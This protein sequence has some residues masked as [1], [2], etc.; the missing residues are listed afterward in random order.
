MMEGPRA[1]DS[2]TLEYPKLRNLEF[3]PVREGETQ[4]VGLRDPQGISKE[5][6]F[7]PPNVFYLIQF[8]DGQHSRNQIAGEYLKRFG[9]LLLPNWVDKFLTEL[10]EKLFLEGER[11][12]TAKKALAEAY[13][14]ETIRPAAH[15][16]KSYDADPQKVEAQLDECFRSKE[17]PGNARSEH[18][19]QRIKAIVVPHVEFSMAGPIYAWAYKE[20]READTPDVFVILGAARGIIET[21][22]ACTDKDFATP[23]GTVHADREFLRLLRQHGGQVFFE[24]EMAHQNDHAVEFQTL[25][26][27]HSLGKKKPFTIVPILCSFSHL[28]FS[29]PDLVG[30]GQRISEF[31]AAFRK[32]VE[33]Y[34]KQVCF[35]A[36]GDLSH[37]GMR[38]GDPRPPTDFQF[39]KTMQADLAML[40]L[41]EK[42]DADALLQFI[43]REDDARRTGIFPALYTMLNLLSV[44]N[45]Q[46]LRYDRAT[47]DQYNS[48][49]TYCAMAY[50]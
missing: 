38:Y 16:G 28:H 20:I 35:I 32:T 46:V 48:T 9:E 8:L 4:S 42:G 18:A 5:I 31:I 45:G 24:E 7:L 34:D 12:D 37:I 47:V 36:S 30:Q 26:L 40:K 14:K 33:A 11:L 49:V 15:A 21:L 6:L 17:G 10:D 1:T 23:L 27:Q 43:Q 41:A 25:F 13:R 22:F 29:H 44:P 39:N 3:F 19:G 2:S 50:Y